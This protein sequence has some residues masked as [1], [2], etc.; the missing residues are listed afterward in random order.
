M[1]AYAADM[2]RGNPVVKGQ[3][4]GWLGDSGNAEETSAHLHFEMISPEGVP[5]NPY[6]AL[7][8]APIKYTVNRSEY[9]Q[10]PNENLPYG[11]H[12]GGVNI[13][14]GNFDTDSATEIVTGA[15][16]KGGPHIKRYESDMSF[17]GKEFFAYD[18]N[19]RGGSDVAAGDVDG[20]G[21][22]EIIT[23]AGPGGGPHVKVFT[24]N[25][26]EMASFFAYDSNFDKGIYVA[27]GD[28]DGDGTDEIVTGPGVGGGPNVKIFK[29]DGRQLSS[30]FAYDEGFK[31]GVDVAVGDVV[32]DGTDEI[33][34]G[35]GPG[36]GPHVRVLSYVSSSITPIKFLADFFAYDANS[37]HGGVRVSVGNVKKSSAKAEILTAPHSNGGPHVKMFSGNGTVVGNSMFM[38]Q[39]WYG[40]HDIAAGDGF[41]LAGTGINRRASIRQAF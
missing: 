25:G 17:H 36:G 26:V 39:W 1:N 7:V 14:T 33:I 40:F 4:V 35:A 2:K 3:L 5:L 18:V 20:D 27:A 38:E 15:G 19:F 30:F 11:L 41:G 37:Y 34:T 13:A 21:T 24:A 32:S 10:L 28:V 22:D 8:H 12:E 16:I 29:Y 6:D 31:G 23:G 9:P